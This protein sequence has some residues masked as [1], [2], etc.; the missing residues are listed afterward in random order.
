MK[1]LIIES[2]SFDNIE[3]AVNNM[4]KDGFKPI[5][6]ICVVVISDGSTDK[7][8]YQAMINEGGIV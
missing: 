5:G 7:H 3:V 6:G 8:Y 4:I 2:Y 1:Y